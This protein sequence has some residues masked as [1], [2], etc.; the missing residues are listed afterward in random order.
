MQS[1]LLVKPFREAT[2]TFGNI[3]GLYTRTNKHKV[4]MLYERAIEK[5]TAIIALTESHLRSG[6]LEAEIYMNGYQI[7]RADRLEGIRK[8]GVI[9]YLREDLNAHAILLSKGSNGVVEWINIYLENIH[10]FFSCVYRPPTCETE[11]FSEFIN[12]MCSDIDGLGLP[13]P[14]I[15]LC[16]DFNLPGKKTDRYVVEETISRFKLKD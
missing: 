15:V 6:I 12:A 2:I 11:K 1:L 7:Y 13:V 4:S 16:G 5:N 10:T 8:G 9:V 3:E 14:N